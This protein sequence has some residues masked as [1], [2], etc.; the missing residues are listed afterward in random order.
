MDRK[1]ISI[2]DLI[3][4]VVEKRM[5]YDDNANEKS[6]DEMLVSAN[7]IADRLEITV[8]S[9][10]ALAWVV[11]ESSFGRQVDRKFLMLKFHE[12]SSIETRFRSLWILKK[13]RFVSTYR[14]RH[15]PLLLYYLD[16]DQS[17]RVLSG[18]IETLFKENL[19]NE[20]ANRRI[21]AQSC[22]GSDDYNLLLDGVPCG[23][24]FESING[25]YEVYW[26][27]NL[28]MACDNLSTI[29]ETLNELLEQDR[30]PLQ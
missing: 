16:R 2:I 19:I 27:G 6:L 21:T 28:V 11:F 26:K 3:E 7:E 10:C 1:N 22:G 18:N 24:V 20:H 4:S 9:A 14:V 29:L 17:E 8:E 23:F 25:G 13:R 15:S 5:D 30:L 12:N